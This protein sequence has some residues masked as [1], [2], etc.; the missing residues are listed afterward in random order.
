MLINK[1]WHPK[2]L[3]GFQGKVEELRL[4]VK[5]D[6]PVDEIVRMELE[7]L[8]FASSLTWPIAQ[9]RFYE[10]KMQGAAKN[11]YTRSFL[12]KEGTDRRRDAEAKASSEVRVAEVKAFEAEV[13]RKL[14][15]D[16]KND[17]VA[18]HYA[19]KAMLSE[20]TSEKKF[21]Y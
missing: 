21:G 17:F 11:E 7:V 18:I 2:D 19:L 14:L 5:P 20:K 12:T 8:M 13:S 9:A 3:E 15:E 6:L 1:D 16:V 10:A 4:K